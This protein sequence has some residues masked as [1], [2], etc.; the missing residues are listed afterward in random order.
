MHSSECPRSRRLTLVIPAYD[1]NALVL[2]VSLHQ[3]V[4]FFFFPSIFAMPVHLVTVIHLTPVTSYSPASF[5]ESEHTRYW[6]QAQNDLYQVNEIFKLF[7]LLR[8]LWTGLW[9]WQVFAT[10]AC[11]LGQWIF[12]PISRWEEGRVGRSLETRREIAE[13]E[14]ERKTEVEKPD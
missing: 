13:S 2:Y 9:L 1:R 6:I 7:S 5:S 8:I 12:W 11:V 3:V 4:Q 10:F 14:R